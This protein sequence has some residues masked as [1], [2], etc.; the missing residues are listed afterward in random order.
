MSPATG[1]C[2]LWR[3][4]GLSHPAQPQR[5]WWGT[6]HTSQSCVNGL[7]AEFH[8]FPLVLKPVSDVAREAC[9][10]SQRFSVDCV[11]SRV[12]L[13]GWVGAGN[14]AGQGDQC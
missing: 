5:C 11:L 3:Q 10:S 9:S 6:E 8:G 4:D 1:N 12:L 13:L 7:E 2:G 14:F